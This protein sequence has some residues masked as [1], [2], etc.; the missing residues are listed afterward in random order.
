MA[1]QAKLGE[2]EIVATV[3]KAGEKVETFNPET[4]VYSM[5]KTGVRTSDGQSHTFSGETVTVT[6]AERDA[7]CKAVGNERGMTIVRQAAQ[8]DREDLGN[9]LQAQIRGDATPTGK[10]E[11]KSLAKLAHVLDASTLKKAVKQALASGVPEEE[12]RAAFGADYD[13]IVS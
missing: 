11:S 7:I 12:L 8:S 1:V 13:R 10:S 3:N 6:N 4:G 9:K 2:G 5:E